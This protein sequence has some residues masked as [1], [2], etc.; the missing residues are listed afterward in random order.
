M[1]TY[2]GGLQ[3]SWPAD[4]GWPGPPPQLGFDR[5]TEAIGAKGMLPLQVQ[6][7]AVEYFET[8]VRVPLQKSPT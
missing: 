8:G 1:C 5:R 6:A 7:D 2:P 4:F 3:L